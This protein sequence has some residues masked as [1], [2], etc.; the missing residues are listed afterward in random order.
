MLHMFTEE[1]KKLVA[2]VGDLNARCGV[3]QEVYVT[4]EASEFIKEWMKI[5][6]HKGDQSLLLGEA[7]DMFTTLAVYF[8][9]TGVTDE[10]IEAHMQ[11]KIMRALD[12]NHETGEI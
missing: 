6:R 3:P 12:R 9:R 7:M 4:E 2:E 8:Y 5:S 10:Q 1:T 11:S